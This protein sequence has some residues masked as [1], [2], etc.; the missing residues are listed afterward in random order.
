MKC[1]S[2]GLAAIIG[3]SILSGAGHAQSGDD[4]DR[5]LIAVLE[6]S[7]V[8]APDPALKY[9]LAESYA[10]LG[11]RDKALEALRVVVAS[12]QP[13]L[14]P[15]T[16]PL[17][18]YAKD[19]EFAPLLKVLRDRVPVTSNGVVEFTLSGR[20]I[21]TEGIAYDDSSRRVF[22]GD[23]N[24]RS[25]FEISRLGVVKPFVAG[26]KNQPYGMTVDLKR[27]Y[28]WVVLSNFLAGEKTPRTE[29]MRI[30]LDSRKT[31]T[32]SHPEARSLNDLVVGPDG[33]VYA[34]DIGA[35]SVWRISPAT[36]RW[37]ALVKP[38]SVSFPN[39]I[40]IDES[41]KRIFLAQG[42]RIVAINLADG[43][44]VPIKKPDTLSTLGT[45]GLYYRDGNLFGIQNITSPG[46]VVRMLLNKQRDEITG[47]DVIES[48]NPIFDL[49]TTGAFVGDKFLIIANS[50][51]YRIDRRALDPSQLKPVVLLSYKVP[52]P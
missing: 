25:I 39:G 28:L 42:R 43:S 2:L 27:R 18:R 46:R 12:N 36:R 41:G 50:Q 40:A 3:L 17:W 14:P 23:L 21:V 44:M 20:P 48:A 15:E 6:E 5:A 8:A 30:H 38:G 10:R 35:A 4:R 26:L 49:P 11:Q 32:F 29:L 16:N 51:I 47:F 9:L 37:T 31:A 34:S 13:F 52:K 33:D 7:Y 45:D 24:S 1:L 19:G 22:V